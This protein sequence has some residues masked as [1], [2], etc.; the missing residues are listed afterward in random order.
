MLEAHDIFASRYH[1]IDASFDT[2]SRLRLCRMH[3]SAKRENQVA[4]Y[5]RKCIGSLDWGSNNEEVRAVSA[6]HPTA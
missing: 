2:I 6:I 4:P 1:L 5:Q 3:P